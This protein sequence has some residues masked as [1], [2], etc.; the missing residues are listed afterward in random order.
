MVNHKT[1]TAYSS[2]LAAGV[3]MLVNVWNSTFLKYADFYKNQGYLSSKT[4][5]LRN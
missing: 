4:Q 3:Q 2:V 1:W 5:K